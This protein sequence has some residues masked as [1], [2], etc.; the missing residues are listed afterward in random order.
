MSKLFLFLLSLFT[1]NFYGSMLSLSKI[2][3]PCEHPRDFTK[4]QQEILLKTYDYAKNTDFKWV[5]PAIAWQ[6]SCAGAYPINFKDPSAGVFHAHIPNVLKKYTHLKDTSLNR[7]LI[8]QYLIQDFNFAL[9]VAMDELKFWDRNNNLKNTIKSYNKGSSWK[10]DDKSNILAERY[11]DQVIQ[12]AQI[13]KSYLPMLKNTS[14]LNTIFNTKSQI[15]D[16]KDMDILEN[17]VDS[18]IKQPEFFLLKER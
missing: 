2:S 3:L 8:G 5:L 9:K 1:S 13:L 11:Y 16:D 7:N 15:Q 17:K 12:K 14:D 4:E 18:K 10:R 6:E